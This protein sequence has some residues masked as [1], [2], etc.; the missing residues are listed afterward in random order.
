MG[1]EADRES[2]GTSGASIEDIGSRR[3]V[4][5]YAN[6]GSGTA[7]RGYYLLLRSSH[8]KFACMEKSWS[9]GAIGEDGAAG[10]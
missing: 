5:Q 1:Y 7:Y 9:A 6:E 3:D 10:A 2:G 8:N 4:F